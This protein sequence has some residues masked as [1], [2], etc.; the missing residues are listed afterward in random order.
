MPSNTNAM[1]ALAAVQN[2]KSKILG[3]RM[4]RHTVEPGLHIPKTGT[5]YHQTFLFHS[6]TNPVKTNL[7][8]R[9]TRRASCSL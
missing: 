2:D 9:S 3:V 7:C 1:G 8:Y 6:Y 5:K 4:G